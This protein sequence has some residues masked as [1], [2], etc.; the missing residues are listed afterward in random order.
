MVNKTNKKNAKQTGGKN[1]KKAKKAGEKKTGKH[2]VKLHRNDKRAGHV[3]KL[4]KKGGSNQGAFSFLSPV[5]TK[6]YCKLAI[7][8]PTSLLDALLSPI[9]KSSPSINIE[10]PIHSID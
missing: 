7:F 10:I 9:L 8:I 6:I 5:F 3:S 2:A 1:S 4:A